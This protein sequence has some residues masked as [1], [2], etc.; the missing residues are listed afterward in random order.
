MWTAEDVTLIRA[1]AILRIDALLDGYRSRFDERLRACAA[2]SAEDHIAVAVAVFCA[3]QR[4]V[5]WLD[6]WLAHQRVH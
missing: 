3:R 4:A 1:A 5:E 6:K 2:A